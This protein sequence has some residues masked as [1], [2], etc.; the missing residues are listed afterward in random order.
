[1]TEEP[2]HCSKEEEGIEGSTGERTEREDCLAR[3]Q[4]CA[5]CFMYVTL[6]NPRDLGSHLYFSEESAKP[7]T[8]PR[9]VP[10]AVK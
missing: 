8:V 2:L 6:F 5:K 1:M 10:R 7:R 3:E 4:V 9:V